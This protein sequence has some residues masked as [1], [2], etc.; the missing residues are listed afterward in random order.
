MVPLDLWDV[1]AT[2][3]FIAARDR[4]IPHL[5]WIIPSESHMEANPAI[6][7][8]EEGVCC[9]GRARHFFAWLLLRLLGL[10]RA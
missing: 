8:T 3:R 1:L 5:R 6:S 4:C 9:V 10:L 7:A 2:A